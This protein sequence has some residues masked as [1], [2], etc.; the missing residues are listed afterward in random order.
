MTQDAGAQFRTESDTATTEPLFFIGCPSP[1]KA[2]HFE[3]CMISINALRKRQSDFIAN[4]W[5]L[6]SGAF[7]ELSR[8]S[9]YRHSV[10]EYA[11]EIA[12]WSRCGNLQA[13][14]SQDYMCEPFIL[15]RTGLTIA[16][17]QRLTI[18]RYDALLPLVSVP[19]MP[20]LQG[21]RVS[22][23]LAHLD[24]YGSRLAP[25]A[26]VGVGSVCRR[27]SRP[28]EVADILRAIK[29]KR[30]DLR[31]HGFGLKLTA[32][33][34]REVRECLH[35]SD[36]MAWSYPARYG[37]GNDSIETADEYLARVRQALADYVQKRPPA[38]AGAGNGQG[39]KPKWNHTP[40]TAIRVPA[41]FADRL[42]EAA[43]EWDTPALDSGQAMI[44]PTTLTNYDGGKGQDGVFQRIINQAPRHDT[45]IEPFLGG[46]AV[47]RLKR[48]A[49]RSIGV[50]QDP[51]IIEA[52]R[53]VEFPGLS[54]HCGD[55]IK[56]LR[57]YRWSGD[58]FVYCDPPYPFSV[59]AYKQKLYRFEMTERQHRE[60]L[61][62]IKAIPAR[63]AISSYWSSMY[64][65]ALSG[66]RVVSFQA[67]KRN[68]ETATEWL[69]MNYEEPLELHDYSYLGADYRERERIKRRCKRWEKRLR[70]MPALERYAIMKALENV[71][72]AG[73]L[74]ISGDGRS[75]TRDVTKGDD[76]G[77]LVIDSDRA[78]SCQF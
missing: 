39:R 53:G 33:E 69:W 45:Y 59:R 43:R 9:H 62:M 21:F 6:D 56:F 46:G 30:P 75:A 11:G 28:D 24:A 68:G 34:S 44:F 36:S 10:E 78:H 58:E 50:D 57:S 5:I 16:D 70:E 51:K 20:V 73:V 23:Y 37:K 32:L 55:G 66:W 41:A 72:D 14:V 26:W 1:A 77:G 61:E 38:T 3:R 49:R 74:D 48:P 67:V 25:G 12:R 31:L 47:M 15:V 42:I 27:N 4:D 40:T 29:N 19:L 60:L 35:S 64:A 65:E 71:R 63:V 17:H 52:W 2:R 76:S 18:E 7:S 8:F 22:D 54:L 13:A